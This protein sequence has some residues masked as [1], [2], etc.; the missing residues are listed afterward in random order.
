MKICRK[1]I[2]GKE[3]NKLKKKNGGEKQNCQKAIEQQTR[4]VAGNNVSK[5]RRRL[6]EL[7]GKSQGV[8]FILGIMGNLCTEEGDIKTDTTNGL[9]LVRTQIGA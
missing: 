6:Q 2:P 7:T 3:K 5:V 4:E 1:H 9:N 8:V